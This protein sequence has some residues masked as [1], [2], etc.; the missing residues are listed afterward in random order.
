MEKV[1]QVLRANVVSESGKRLGRVVELRCPGEPEHGN[2]KNERV[3]G[4][5]LYAKGGF[6]ERIGL[7][8]ANIKRA[9]WQFVKKIEPNTI[10]ISSHVNER[11]G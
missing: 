1:T 2:S 7:R 4:E 10:V 11:L 6:L 5:L 3:V 8:K 9:P